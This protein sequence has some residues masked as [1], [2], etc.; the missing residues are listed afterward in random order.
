MRSIVEA[1]LAQGRQQPRRVAIWFEDQVISYAQLRMEIERFALGLRRQGLQPGDRVGLYLG[2]RPE[3]VVVY[4]GTQ[5]AGGVAVP[6]NPQYRRGELGH[7]LDDAQPSFCVTD[8][9][10]VAEVE[11]L[12][13]QTSPLTLV[14]LDD[15]GAGSE[16]TDRS[17]PRE[18][19]REGFSR[20]PFADLLAQGGKADAD[21][22]AP[23][24]AEAPA[25][26]IYTSGTTG[27]AKGAVHLHRNLYANAA[28]V[29]QAWRWAADDVLLLTLPLFHMHGLCVGVHGALLTGSSLILR[30][31]FDAAEVVDTLRRDD[32]HV[33]LCF[34][35]P[36]MYGRLLRE[37]E[38]RGI[39]PHLPRLFVS[40]SAPLS[41]QHFH[42]FERVFGSRILERYGM[43][44]TGMNL[45][46][47]YDGERRAG[48]V[49]MPFPNQE[50]RVVDVRTRQL[51]PAGTVG[52][53]EVR[54]P[55]VFAG[56]WQQPEATA[57]AFSADGW[58]KTGDLG[59]CSADGY[60][61]I[62]G[63]LSEL[64]ISGGYNVYPREVEDVLAEHPA[65]AE[66]AVL[67]LPDAELGEQV[68]AVVVPTSGST[69]S[70]DELIAFCR[71][72]LASYKKPRQVMFVEALPRNALGKVQKHLLARDLRA[73]G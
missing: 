64:I 52:E 27:R 7:I 4:F 53:I 14:L 70:A 49:G 57:A 67:S 59:T 48:T 30:D 72:R 11:R 6:I 54:G 16:A 71:E 2:N 40:G 47:P 42:A 51:L 65:I 50:A 43:S 44:E 69:P 23:P 46:N 34:G 22:L 9:P 68:V 15:A 25:L 8:G 29:T 45:T 63:R 19:E 38:Q 73:H 33:T 20:M 24:P 18:A 60:F 3:F 32:P 13:P 37:A 26:M 28:A 21:P 36:T 12:M 56:Y 31:R 5:L 61:T 66:V 41:P 58:F 55:H 1:V 39:P 35:V 62:T 10:H 17:R